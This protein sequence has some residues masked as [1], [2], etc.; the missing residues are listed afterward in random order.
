MDITHAVAK[1][2][3]AQRVI[4][5]VT[6]CRLAEASG[7]PERTLSRLLSGDAEIKVA[8]LGALARV[9]GST[10]SEIVVEGERI[11]DRAERRDESE[12]RA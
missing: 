3:A 5:G 4:A 6:I 10:T 8:Q 9:L 11:L 7:I 1:A 12:G 2:L